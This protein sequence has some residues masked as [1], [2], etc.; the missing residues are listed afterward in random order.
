M[1]GLAKALPGSVVYD[2]IV[3]KGQTLTLWGRARSAPSVYRLGRN[4]ISS[5]WF[6]TANLEVINT[7]IVDGESMSEFELTVRE[8]NDS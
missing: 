4:L 6:E 7:T 1:E 3:G 2:R 5:K 8:R